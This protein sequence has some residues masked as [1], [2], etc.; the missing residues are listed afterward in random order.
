MRAKNIQGNAAKKVMTCPLPP[1]APKELRF[2]PRDLRST[3][4]SRDTHKKENGAAVIM[5]ISSLALLVRGSTVHR[6]IN[7]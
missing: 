5:V 2:S 3:R 4:V 7:I 1:P 6:K